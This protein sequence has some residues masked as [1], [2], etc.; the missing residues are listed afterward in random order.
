MKRNDL[1]LSKIISASLLGDGFIL[2]DD[3]GNRNRNGQFRIKQIEQHKDHLDYLADRLSMLTNIKLD[4]VPGKANIVICNKETK[5]SGTYILRTQNHPEYT[6]FRSRWY[7]DGIKRIDPHAMTLLDAEMLAIW[8]QQDGYIEGSLRKD[9]LNNSCLICTDCF[10]YGDQKM[11]R[12][13]IIEKTG[14]IFNILKW[15]KNKNGENT[16]RLS[17][18]R[19]QTEQFIEYIKPFMQPSF[20]YKLNFLQREHPKQDDDIVCSL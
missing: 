5:A 3:S 12:E 4:Y 7:I 6:K 14:F 1:Y 13:A 15:S 2:K 8:Y 17:L 9:C 11:L 16:Y 19:K 20:E 10:S 18:Y